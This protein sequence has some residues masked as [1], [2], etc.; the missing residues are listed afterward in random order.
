MTKRDEYA[1]IA[2]LYDHVPIYRERPDI[3]FFVEAAREAGSPVL[4]LGC[5]TGR[6][7]LPTARAGI[8]ITGLDASP[9]MLA[10]CRRF[11]AGESEAVR[12]RVRL[13][14]G[15]MRSFALE[16]RF[17]L[18]TLPF[19][20]FQHLTTVEDQLACLDRIRRHLLPGGRVILDLFNPSLE[21][22]IQPTGVETPES[23]FTAP[24]GRRVARLFKALS[25]DRATQVIELELIYDVTHLDG[26][27]ERL[28]QSTALRYSFRFEVEHLL[29]RAGFT[30]EHLYAGYDKS[31]FGSVYPGDLI[32]VARRAD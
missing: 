32:F 24:D 30:V 19:R 22:L 27:T 26:R 1:E 12:A 31:P 10:L 15:D 23:E 18:V 14:E 8:T 4:E 16:Q 17:T 29:A 20:P 9:G 7:L 21:A 13:V 5:G 28:V 6:V 11:L 2:D 3:G 25:R